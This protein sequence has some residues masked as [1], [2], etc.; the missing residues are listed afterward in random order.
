MEQKRGLLV[1]AAMG[2]GKTTFIDNV[3]ESY[4][5]DGDVLLKNLGVKN[6]NDFWYDAKYKEEQRLIIDS[7]DYYLN[8]GYW[9]FYS[10]NPTIMYPDV[11]ILPDKKERWRR[12]QGRIRYRPTQEKFIL[13]QRAYEGASKYTYFYINGNI[14]SLDMFHCMYNELI[15]QNK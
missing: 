9:I 7:F 6:R 5:L 14:P 13:E 12:L 10:G 4:I 1:F 2:S 11:V 8:L 3:N 15:Q